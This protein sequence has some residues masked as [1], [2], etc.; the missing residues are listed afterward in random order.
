MG[1]KYNRRKSDEHKFFK[2]M[3]LI[4]FMATFILL[5]AQHFSEKPEGY[6]Q[7]RLCMDHSKSL[8][9]ES[10][11]DPDTKTIIIKCK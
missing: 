6:Y 3:V 4:A 2:G 8:Y 10:S 5:L 9:T 7:N 11:Y 1:Q